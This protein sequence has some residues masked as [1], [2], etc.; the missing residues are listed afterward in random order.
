MRHK[1]IF[2]FLAG[3]LVFCQNPVFA[4]KRI[5]GLASGGPRGIFILL[6]GGFPSRTH[7][8]DS[9][10][11]YRLERREPPNGTWLE[12]IDVEAPNTI[13]EFEARLGKSLALVD[14]LSATRQIPV[15]ELWEKVERYRRADSLGYWGGVL[16]VR[17]ALGVQYLDTTAVKKTTYEYRISK[18]DLSG[19]PG[20]AVVTNTISYPPLV[21]FSQPR[22]VEKYGT[23][24]QVVLR[25][26]TGIGE[27]PK[28]FAVFRR[29]Q[30]QGDFKL[31][32]PSQLIALDHDTTLLIVDD[33]LITPVQTYYYY[34]VPMDYYGNAGKSS[35]TALVTT[36]DFRTV[37]LPENIT[38]KSSDSV[39]GI[40]LTW[41]LKEM[42]NVK[43]VKIYRSEIWDSGYVQIG[44]VP[45]RGTTYVDRIVEPMKQYNYYLVMTGLSGEESP[46][47]AR[48][49]GIFQSSQPPL[50]PWIAKSE[51]LKIGVRLEIVSYEPFIAGYRVYRSD[52]YRMALKPI[53]DLVP[54]KDSV[55][56]FVDS[57]P[58]LSGKVQYGYAVRAENT[59][60]IL[61]GFSDT[62][63]VR[64][65]ILTQP[66]TPLNLLVSRGDTGVRLYWTDMVPLD[67]A[68]DG[69]WIY[70]RE[71]RSAQNLAGFK[72][73]NDSLV[74]ANHNYFTDTTVAEGKIY[75]FAVQ[76]ADIFG[77]KSTLSAPAQIELAISLSL[78]PALVRAERAEEGVLIQWE[79]PSEDS[80]AA[81]KIYR[82]ERGK[83]PRLLA[84]VAKGSTE[85]LDKTASAGNLYF[86]Y[87]TCVN[88]KGSESQPS[89][90]VGF[91]R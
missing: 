89:D 60:H 16:A 57:S 47:S 9:I 5:E 14:E 12:V 41:N 35:D 45:S 31:I 48:V 84:R 40:R 28:R 52:G 90:E 29:E 62:V 73:I 54:C 13:G 75:E 81:Y 53:S 51:G 7:P 83:E 42:T 80:I 46:P 87:L 77:G 38:A 2:G 79:E 55:T 64:P 11:A 61:S 15:Q 78:A 56:V 76:S 34:I 71:V 19:K 88:T 23:R 22:L 43:S 69:Y 65:L 70:R 18:L 74:S 27:R 68:L 59:S 37:P 49:F 3:L 58:G 26:R 82:Y 10:T 50:P 20:V 67:D 36:F 30:F 66:P 25:W 17:L 24:Q 91:R 32:R 1:L 44:E 86:Y 6:G 4:Q 8:A 63:Y 21:K 33:T 85:F 39:G 72:K